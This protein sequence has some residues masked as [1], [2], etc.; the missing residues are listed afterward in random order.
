MKY[1]NL[2]E[3]V[4][5]KKIEENEK[6]G[7]FYVEGLYTG[8][9]VTFGNS[10]R[11]VLFSSLPGAAIT[12]VKI[13]GVDHEFSTLPGMIEDIIDFSLNFV[14]FVFSFFGY[15]LFYRRLRQMNQS[16]FPQGRSP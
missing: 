14:P 4:S 13:K 9:G 1:S 6:V 8:Y 11:R 3:S 10:L 7:V 12:K 2:G 15:F 16:L 5:I